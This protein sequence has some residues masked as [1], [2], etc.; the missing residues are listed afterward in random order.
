[1]Q[2][3]QILESL[4]K[5]VL[6]YDKERAVEGAKKALELGLNPIEALE[7]GL[8]RGIR[9]VGEKFA[10]MEIFLPHVVM[11]AE[12]MQAAAN[13]LLETLPKEEADKLSAGTIVIGTVKGDI[14]D[15]GKSL[16]KTMLS[17]AGFRVVDLGVDVPIFEFIRK[18]KESKADII[19][20]S[21]LMTTT[22]AE[23]RDLIEE[24]K[25]RG[26][27]EKFKV[28]VGGGAV[29]E[30]WAREIGAD[31][32]GSDMKKAVEEAERLIRGG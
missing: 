30:D 12:A 32:Y 13:V 3:D 19:A 29:T 23:Q 8:A 18:A 14:H 27:R 25:R 26:E 17:A 5:A 9:E 10:R 11:A 20:M 16:V 4:A 31:G 7:K 22:I 2:K 21:A 15:I 28:L 24:L 1:L 6:E